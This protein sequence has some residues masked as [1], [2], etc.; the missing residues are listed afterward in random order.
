MGMLSPQN[1]K[2]AKKGNNKAQN[3]AQGSKFILKPGKNT[4]FVKK[5][6]NTGT[7]RGS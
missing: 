7:K 4:G 3:N 1:N 2:G 5:K 6:I